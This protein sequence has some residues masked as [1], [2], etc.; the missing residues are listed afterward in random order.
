MLNP[1]ALANAASAVVGIW[2]VACLLLSLIAPDLVLAI[3]Q[4]W[5]HTINL[6][7]AKATVNAD[8]GSIILGFVTLVG[9]TW[10][11]SYGT[12]VLYNKWYK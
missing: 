1:K 2:F 8:F 10:I 7:A 6:N 9:L 11:T 12:I 4:S 5:V 3:G